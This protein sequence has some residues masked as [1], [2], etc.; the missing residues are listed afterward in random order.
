MQTV[1][2]MR[3]LRAIAAQSIKTVVIYLFLM[4]GWNQLFFPKLVPVM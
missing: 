3:R 2:E 1:W 4:I